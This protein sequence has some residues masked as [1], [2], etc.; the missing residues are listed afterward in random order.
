VR[1]AR[2]SEW[3]AVAET[4]A[5]AL[6]NDPFFLWMVAR[7][8]PLTPSVFYRAEVEKAL[9]RNDRID[10]TDRHESVAIW[11][12]PPDRHTDPN[13]PEDVREAF[14]EVN[15]TAGRSAISSFRG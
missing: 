6:A 9:A 2:P 4:L 14:D 3:V 15:S 11:M 8:F 5:S 7:G 13:L 12:P 1:Q 10:T